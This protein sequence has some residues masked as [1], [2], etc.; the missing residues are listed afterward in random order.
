M[1]PSKQ[2]TTIDG[3]TF[4]R[5][6]YPGTTPRAAQQNAY[7]AWVLTIATAELDDSL[8]TTGEQVGTEI[9][10]YPTQDAIKI[11]AHG[12]FTGFDAQALAKG[13]AAAATMLKEFNFGER[14]PHHGGT[15][16]DCEGCFQETDPEG[17]AEILALTDLKGA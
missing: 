2:T 8:Y 11:S 16:L 1:K 15:D 7:S 13:L 6:N 3:L 12:G 10:V 14:C 9:Q 4:T 17:Y 5:W